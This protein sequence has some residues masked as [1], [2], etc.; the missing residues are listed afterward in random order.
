MTLTEAKQFVR[1]CSKAELNDL[2]QTINGIK[3]AERAQAK[4]QF[5]VGD[6]V[7]SDDPRWYY[8]SGVI[9][10]IKQKNIVVN[11]DGTMVNASIGLLKHYEKD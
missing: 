11:C 10:S 8:G 1:N 7:T 3:K 2:I 4:A 9:V 6:I 5:S